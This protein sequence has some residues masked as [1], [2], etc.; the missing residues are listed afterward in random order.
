M[1]NII[2]LHSQI[3]NQ[4][5]PTVT[6]AP[7]S[8]IPCT[9]AVVLSVSG[10]LCSNLGKHPQD[11]YLRHLVYPGVLELSGSGSRM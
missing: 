7:E 2:K 3:M 8:L 9:Q 6:A 1:S 4:Q 11:L 5:E 10:L